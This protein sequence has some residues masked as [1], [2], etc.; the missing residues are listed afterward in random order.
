MTTQDN[1]N[2]LMPYFNIYGADFLAFQNKISKDEWWDICIALSDE[3]IFGTTNFIA[4]NDF[5]KMLYD[6]IKLQKNKYKINFE[7]LPTT[8]YILELSSDNERF[9]KIGISCNINQRINDYKR[10]GYQVEIIDIINYHNRT[11][12]FLEE[13]RLHEF[14]AKHKYYPE[15]DFG[16]KTEC[17]DIVIKNSLI[18]KTYE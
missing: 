13:C 3:C 14:Y 16:G 6:K 12:A 2:I 1:N 7:D 9:V 15:I 10:I 17:F 11:D 4:K 18:L 5:Q 8:T